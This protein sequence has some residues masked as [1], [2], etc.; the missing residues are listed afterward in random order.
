MVKIK[1]S[2][3]KNIILPI[4]CFGVAVYFFLVYSNNLEGNIGMS[5]DA[6]PFLLS[7]AILGFIFGILSTLSLILE[8][9]RLDS[10]SLIYSRVFK[11]YKISI[12]EI[13]LIE[14][15]FSIGN[16]SIQLIFTIKNQNG[17]MSTF[18]IND[19]AT[20]RYK[21]LGKLASEIIQLNPA[22]ELSDNVKKLIA[23]ENIKLWATK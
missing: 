4:I 6:G 18:V 16:R 5:I 12:A 13:T 17:T 2:V 22:V 1:P 20:Y 11:K 10:G 9:I 7:V 15:V 14:Y 19:A 8:N 21:D 3:G 23:G